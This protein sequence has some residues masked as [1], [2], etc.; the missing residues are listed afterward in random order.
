[1][2]VVIRRNGRRH[3]ISGW[4]KWAISV[5]LI[6]VAALV[7]AVVS[8]LVLGAVLTLGAILLIGI[9]AALILALIV[10][11]VMPRPADNSVDRPPR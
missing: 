9:P 3:E 7:I 2:K 4:R 8:L 5:L 1:M 10:G 11:L 6:P